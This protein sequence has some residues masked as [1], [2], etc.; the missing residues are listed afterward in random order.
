MLNRWQERFGP[1][2]T[3][4]NLIIAFHNAQKMDYVDV[5]CRQLGGKSSHLSQ[6]LLVANEGI[7]SAGVCPPT[8]PTTETGQFTYSIKFVQTKFLI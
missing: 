6:C 8:T 5:V 3:Y 1:E 2:A 4:R 7:S